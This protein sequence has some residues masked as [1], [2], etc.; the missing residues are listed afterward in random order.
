MFITILKTAYQRVSTIT[1]S[2]KLPRVQT[3]Q[4]FLKYLEDAISMPRNDDAEPR[5]RPPELKAYMIESKGGFPSKISSGGMTGEVQDTGLDGIKILQV[6]QNEAVFEFFLDT[7]NPRFFVLHTN[8][9]SDDVGPIVRTLTKDRRYTF[10]NTW[11]H[12]EMLYN[13]AGKD[14]N[15]FNGFGVKYDNNTFLS[16]D[17]GSDSAIIDDLSININGSLAHRALDMFGSE[18]DI[19]K[20]IA[21]NKVRVRR[22][23]DL[24]SD[25]IQDDVTYDG[26]LSVKRGKSAQDHLH[27]VDMCREEYSKTVERVEDASIGI[28]EVD[29]RTLVDGKSFDFEFESPI[30]DLDL[31]IDRM[32]SSA[33]P[34]KLWGLKSKIQDGYYKITAVDLHAGTTLSFDVADN[35]MRA[36]LFKGSCGNTILRLLT[37]LQIHYDSRIK[38]KQVAG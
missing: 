1:N 21:F 38:C 27:L 2:V 23:Q 22:G 36:Y 14:G 33:E 8:E 15:T 35:L 9:K 18:Q 25:F 31:F 37:N 20:T 32:F 26:Y 5:G 34:F 13:F 24:P 3:R 4:Q 19:K 17:Y 11:F 6:R 7:T 12:S 10:D 29:G 16:D 30:K 28:K